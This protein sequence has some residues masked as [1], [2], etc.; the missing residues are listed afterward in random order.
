[1][2][3]RV[4]V[5]CR[6]SG[7]GCRVS[8]VGC[9]EIQYYEGEGVPKVLLEA[10]AAGRAV[11]ATDTPGCRE[12]IEDGVE[13]VL[14]P[15]GD[16]AALAQALWRLIEGPDERQAMGVAGRARAVRD[17]SVDQ[18]VSRTLAIYGELRC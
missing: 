18:V 17:L 10:A 1:M 15:A 12:V 14:V 8:G 13:G 6:V 11:V 7:V 3:L 4:G 9:R 5:G 16:S 2:R